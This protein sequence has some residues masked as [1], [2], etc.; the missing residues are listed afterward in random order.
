MGGT[1]S[2]VISF[3]MAPPFR[4]SRSHCWTD[5]GVAGA[6]RCPLYPAA[7]ILAHADAKMTSMAGNGNRA[8]WPI[9]VILM[10]GG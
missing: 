7:E 5:G 3:G 1:P 10:A 4:S 8:V 2:H 9:G 6:P